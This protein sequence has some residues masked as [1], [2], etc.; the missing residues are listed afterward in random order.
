MESI[1]NICILGGGNGAHAISGDL[2]MKG[3]R[4]RMSEL[5]EF[6]DK[7][8]K[9]L[10]KSEVKVTGIK[11]GMARLRKGTTDFSIALTGVELIIVAVPSFAHGT[12]I[13]RAL[14]YLQEGQI[15]LFTLGN[16]STLEA[17]Q[18]L[19]ESGNTSCRLDNNHHFSHQ[20]EGPSPRRA[21]P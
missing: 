6:E 7:F 9:V 16:L 3:F 21:Y 18:L 14:P 2:A 5:P 17:Y 13:E 8:R 20:Q 19:K 10:S 1:T 4:M 11:E 12:F 15:V